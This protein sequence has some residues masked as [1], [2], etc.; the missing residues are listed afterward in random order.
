MTLYIPV[1]NGVISIHI[2]I[3]GFR[4]VTDSANISGNF[5]DAD[6][7]DSLGDTLGIVHADE[8]GQVTLNMSTESYQAAAAMVREWEAED[9]ATLI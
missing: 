8:N 9:T 7:F 4:T 5:A 2:C 3:R 6:V 1:K